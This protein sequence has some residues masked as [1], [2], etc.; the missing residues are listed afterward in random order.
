YD[1]QNQ[2]F[3]TFQG[4]PFFDFDQNGTFDPTERVLVNV[5]DGRAFVTGVE[6]EG[7][8]HL[9]ERWDWLPE[10]LSLRGGFAWN[11][12]KD[13]TRREPLR[14]VHPAHALVA[15]RYEE[16]G[17]R[18]WVEFGGTVVRH[19]DRIPSDRIA[20]DPG[21]RA[22]PQDVTSPLVRPDGSLPG[23]LVFDVRGGVYLRDNVRL[24]L[25][26]ENLTDKQYR[27]LH[28]R[29]DA[30]GFTLRFGITVEF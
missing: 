12:G 3:G 10:G 26:V 15:L 16:P 1:F 19:A 9:S 21:F 14:H 13:R 25:A 27:R 11:F 4:Q 30:P 7:W 17:S 20:T 18:W 22:D 8:V 5:S 29:M 6:I 24:E 23:Y 28:S 2:Q